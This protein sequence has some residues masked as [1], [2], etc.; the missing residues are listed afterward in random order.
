VQSE[1]EENSP[2]PEPVEESPATIDEEQ[3]PIDESPIEVDDRIDDAP[4]PDQPGV[5]SAPVDNDSASAVITEEGDGSV[6]NVDLQQ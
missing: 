4:L 5:D 2:T 3:S 6:D 1:E